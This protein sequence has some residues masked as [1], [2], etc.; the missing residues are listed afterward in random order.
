MVT[1]QAYEYYDEVTRFPVRLAYA[2]TPAQA[3]LLV[4]QP[5]LHII[6]PECMT[7]EGGSFVYAA[8]S[9]ARD[10]EKITWYLSAWQRDSDVRLAASLLL[11]LVQ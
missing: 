7:S 3:S 4:E 2:F 10:W 6:V 9:L 11:V 8:F 5:P 1:A